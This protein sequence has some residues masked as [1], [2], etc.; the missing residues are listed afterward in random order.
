MK[1]ENLPDGGLASPVKNMDKAAITSPFGK[2]N[3]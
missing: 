1:G 3:P 2:L